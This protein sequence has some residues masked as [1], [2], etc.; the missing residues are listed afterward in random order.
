MAAMTESPRAK[1]GW[2]LANVLVLVY[3]FVPIIWIMM[4]IGGL[5]VLIGGA[6]LLWPRHEVVTLG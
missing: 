1:F 5:A 2:G 4:G 3:A 6:A